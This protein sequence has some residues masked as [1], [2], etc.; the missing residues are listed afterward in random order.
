MDH[1]VEP[2]IVVE[3]REHLW[4]LLGAA[5]QLEHMIMCQYL[6]ANFSLKDEGEG[7]TAEQLDA[8][9]RWRRTLH[10]ISVQEMLH[11]ALVSNLVSA[12]GGAPGF[13]R[14][15]F[16]QPSGWFPPSVQLDLLP[17]GEAALTH[18]LYLERPEGMERVDAEGFVPAALPVEPVDPEELFPRVQA[19]STVGHLYRGIA[20]GLRRLVDRIGE[21]G[22]FIGPPEAQASAEAFR[23][24]GLIMVTDLAS[25][26]AAVD[27]IIEQGEGARG[28][29]RT[30][31]YGRFLDIWKEHGELVR[32]D[33]GFQPARP[34]LKAFTRQPY[35]LVQPQVMLTDPLTLTVA[36]LF[37]VGYELTLHV[38]TRYFTHT[39]ETAEQLST[40]SGAAVGL[41]AG[42]LRPLGIALSKLP[43]GPEHPDRT[44][45]AAF[46]MYYPMGNVLPWREPAWVIILER[47]RTLAERCSR[48][49]DQQP[50]V[51]RE[52][53]VARDRLSRIVSR[54]EAQTST[55]P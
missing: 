47:M 48:V 49:V 16:P 5:S 50:G 36:D 22:L 27:E 1:S 25:A 55:I 21:R 41:M 37:N 35:D 31:H 13:N 8:I 46:E 39:D 54:F 17:F 4:G 18:F 14:S 7:L 28:D 40:L 51:P 29:W 53:G 15:N 23:M 11:L 6:Y 30:A 3:H 34:V 26:L 19:F 2:P 42:V 9:S 32:R 43:V 24:P 20:D 44:A 33:P 45:A 10:E 38:L 52:V 12:I